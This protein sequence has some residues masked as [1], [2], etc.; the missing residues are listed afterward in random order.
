MQTKNNIDDNKCV[1]RRVQYKIGVG[2]A[3]IHAFR[4][5]ELLPKVYQGKL[6]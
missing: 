1:N 4:S 6:L 2:D 5:N 3:S